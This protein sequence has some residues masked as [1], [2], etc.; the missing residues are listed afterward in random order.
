MIASNFIYHNSQLLIIFSII[1]AFFAL[2]MKDN[3]SINSLENSYSSDIANIDMY[4]KSLTLLITNFLKILNIINSIIN[5][6]FHIIIASRKIFNFLVISIFY[7]RR[8]G[9][10]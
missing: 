8:G 3:Y 9:T 5:S 7:L 6:S 2:S 10:K 1:S 4:D